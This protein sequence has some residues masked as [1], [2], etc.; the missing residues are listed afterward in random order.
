[1]SAEILASTELRM[2]RAIEA[3]ERDF[4]RIRTGRAYAS[5]LDGVRVDHRGSRTPLDQ[6]ASISIPDPRQI[7]IQPW[8]RSALRAIGKAIAR[9]GIGLTPTIDGSAV[10][11]YFPSLTEEQ[12]REL[13]G[14]VRKRMEQARVDIRTLRHEA[15]AALHK[16]QKARGSGA[17]DLHRAIERLQQM[18]DRFGAE[19]ERL[20]QVKEQRLLEG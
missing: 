20:G 12:R 15:S 1:M 10:R 2:K 8:D 18:T 19:I 17:D 5:L 3:M 16:A 14:L 13:V 9:L 4:Q 6:L 11:L 7:V